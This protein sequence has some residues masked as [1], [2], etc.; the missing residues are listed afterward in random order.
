M[1]ITDN[2]FKGKRELKDELPD[3]ESTDSNSADTIQ[4]FQNGTLSKA[5]LIV[6]HQCPSIELVSPVYACDGAECHL[7]PDQRVI[8]GSTAQSGFNINPS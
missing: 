2:A 5:K 4:S 6:H 1:Y 3:I 8:T 7:L